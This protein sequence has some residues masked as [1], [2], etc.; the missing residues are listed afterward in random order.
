LLLIISAVCVAP[1]AS[2][3]PTPAQVFSTLAP[4]GPS[5]WTVLEIGDGSLTQQANLSNPQGGIYGNVGIT[6]NSHI[7][8]SGPQLHGDLYLGDTASAQ[9]S[10]TYTNN[11]PV[12]GKVHLG[13]GATVSPNTYSFT[14]VSDNPQALLDQARTSA[15]AAS[16]LASSLAPTSALTQINLSHVTMSLNPGVYNL[17]NFHLDHSTLTL[18]GA[19]YYVFN[20]TS[21]FSLSSGKIL[22]SGGATEANV[23]FNYTGTANA[24]F[25]GGTGGTVP[26]G[27]D[28]SVLH[29]ILL[30]LNGQVQMSPGLVVGEIISTKNISIVSG[31][32]VQQ[33]PGVPDVGST[34]ELGLIAFAALVLFRLISPQL[35]ARRSLSKPPT[36]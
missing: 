3:V 16:A 5:Q 4:A 14:T 32:I 23:L 6:K 10:G 26:G 13:S 19:G 7:Q 11:R 34:M 25:T 30:A 17:T 36:G 1:R 8:G 21:L 15:L 31:A 2:A 12:T 18:S 27:L 28:E 9:F 24:A 22:L 35:V 33:P 29:G 20:I